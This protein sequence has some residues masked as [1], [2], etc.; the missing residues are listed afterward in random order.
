[1]GTPVKYDPEKRHPLHWIMGVVV[2]SAG[3]VATMATIV[4]FIA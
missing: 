3:Y 1:V 2:L 4:F